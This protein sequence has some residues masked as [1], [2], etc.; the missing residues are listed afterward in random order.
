MTYTEFEADLFTAPGNAVLA[1]C[2]SQDLKMG[3]GIAAA[4]VARY[5]HGLR[6]EIVKNSESRRV[7]GTDKIRRQV[8]VGDAVRTPQKDYVL[9]NL[10]TKKQYFDKP[11]HDSLNLTLICLRES[12]LANDETLL[13]IPRIAAGI[14]KLSWAKVQRQLYDVFYGMSIDVQMYHRA[15]DRYTP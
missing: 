12:M 15:G 5:G 7:D 11:T 3:A 4:I 1:H 14:D 6:D 2:I 9:Y 13:A 8:W 10:I